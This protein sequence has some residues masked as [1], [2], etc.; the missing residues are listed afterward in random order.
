VNV[1][2]VG[3]ALTPPAADVSPLATVLGEGLMNTKLT[4]GNPVPVPTTP[5]ED[6]GPV[7]YGAE[8]IG[9]TVAVDLTTFTVRY[10]VN[11]LLIVVV[12]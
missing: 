1:L 8:G 10:W 9:T 2:G 12:E 4:L 5:P 6:A 3:V 11:V 7:G